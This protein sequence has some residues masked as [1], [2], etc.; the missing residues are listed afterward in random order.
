[1]TITPESVVI[2]Q[3]DR[4]QL[5]EEGTHTL[6]EF[7]AAPP[8]AEVDEL[9]QDW[10][11]DPDIDATV[12]E[13][14]AVVIEAVDA[15]TIDPAPAP[16]SDDDDQTV[17]EFSER[18]LD[19]EGP[20]LLVPEINEETQTSDLVDDDTQTT[21]PPA[22]PEAV[23]LGDSDAPIPVDTKTELGEL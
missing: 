1:V 7:V 8:Q 14:A 20:E 2:E 11:L 18:T 16:F 9:P 21:E 23:E 22:V 3:P 12:D 6:D 19:D 13:L 10:D 15:E 5:A 17:D 4:P